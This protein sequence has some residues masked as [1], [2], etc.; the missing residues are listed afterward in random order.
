MAGIFQ[1]MLHGMNQKRAEQRQQ[2]EDAFVADER[3]Y[4]QQ[5][6]GVTDSRQDTSWQDGREELAYQQQRRGVT[7]GREDTSWQ[8]GRDDRAYEVGVQRPM[9][10]ESAQL[11]IQQQRFK[12]ERMPIEARQQDARFGV[13]L[14]GA[15]QGNVMR[16]LQVGSAGRA[17]QIEEAQQPDKLDEIRIERERKVAFD[18][19]GATAQQFELAGAQ[20]NKREA[21]QIMNQAWAKATNDPDGDAG[22]RVDESG[23]YFLEGPDGKPIAMLGDESQVV[24]F[25]FQ[26]LSDPR[27]FAQSRQAASAAR[28]QAQGQEAS[29]RAQNPSRFV[30]TAQGADGTMSLIDRGTGRATPVTD[31]SGQPFRGATD[32]R[33]GQM[34]ARL[35][36]VQAIYSRLRPIEGESEDDRY[37]RAYAQ[38]TTRAG[39]DPDQAAADFYETVMRGLLKPDAMGRMTAEM[40]QGAQEQAVALTDYFR[41]SYLSGPSASGLGGGR[42][43]GGDAPAASAP[44][45]APFP[46]G[47]ELVGPD[48]KTYVVRNGIPVLK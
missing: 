3:A 26:F 4:Q 5:R 33:T 39:M 35:Q 28:A 44:Q 6:R 24:E 32:G 12:G 23:K 25:A 31:Q 15:Q 47:A 42:P 9:A 18:S 29:A 8:D 36:E 20:G 21:A 14:E 7:D 37:L 19:L 46:E 43:P 2:S 40:T 27:T 16:S 1:S 38:V 48:G 34:P 22:I 17:A 41:S 13:D 10:A 11:A 30:D 45:P